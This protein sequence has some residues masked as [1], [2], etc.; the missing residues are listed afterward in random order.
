MKLS[1]TIITTFLATG[2]VQASPKAIPGPSPLK[3]GSSYAN[4]MGPL[5]FLYPETRQWNADNDNTAPCGSSAQIQNRSEFP[6]DDGF[7]AF[8]AKYISTKV[9]LSISYNENPTTQDDFDE[10]YNGN[11]SDEL[12]IGHT[13]FFMPDQPNSIN[14]GDV[15]TIQVIYQN[16]DD[17]DQANSDGSPRQQDFNETYYACA[18]IK[19]V[20]KSVFEVSDLAFSCFNATNDDYYAESDIDTASSVATYDSSQVSEAQSVQR[21]ASQESSGASSATASSSLSSSSSSSSSAGAAALGA[22]LSN[23][24]VGF[25]GVLAI[26]AAL[27]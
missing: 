25:T 9:K 23:P 26:F 24:V 20:E 17:E 12:H 1:S 11:V 14:E 2:L 7:I 27:L 3:H 22:V 8:I 16:D 10:W 21:T 4:S 6:L 5:T 18:D 15:A 13:C 19:F